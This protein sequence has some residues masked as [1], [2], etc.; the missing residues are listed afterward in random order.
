M[1]LSEKENVVKEDELIN[2]L[3]NHLRQIGVEATEVA[4]GSPEATGGLCSFPLG[5]VKVEGRNIDLVQ[6]ERESLRATQPNLQPGEKSYTRERAQGSLRYDY[7]YLVRANVAS[8]ENKLKAELKPIEKRKGL[9]GKE[10]VGYQ[11]EGGELAQRLNSDSDLKNMLLKGSIHRLSVV[12]E[13]EKQCVRITP[14]SG[15]ETL[16]FNFGLHPIILGRRMFPTRETF[17]IYDKIAQHIRGLA[18]PRP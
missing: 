9:F 2:E 15:P 1:T 13:K 8:L 17:G 11:W 10:I 7:H 18:G 14:L 16:D 4:S 5:C 3:F 12:P 6:V